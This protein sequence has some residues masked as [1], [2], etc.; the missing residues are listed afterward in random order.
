MPVLRILL[1]V[2][3]VCLALVATA[4][5]TLG[6]AASQPAAAGRSTAGNPITGE[7]LPNPAPNVTR[8]WGQ[9]PEGRKW[10][11]SA[12]VDTL[13]PTPTIAAGPSSVSIRSTRMPATLR[14]SMRTS[15][16]HLT[17]VS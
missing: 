15:L 12:G 16:G 3:G 11:S 14:P 7:G 2:L 6:T 10:G 13:M 9:L 1:P 5:G 4:G 8:N 17:R